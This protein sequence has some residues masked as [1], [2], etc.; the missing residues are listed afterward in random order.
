MKLSFLLLFVCTIGSLSAQITQPRPWS[1]V[2]VYK[3]GQRLNLF[4]QVSFNNPVFAE[5]DLNNN[6]IKD[7]VVLEKAENRLYAFRNNGTPNTIDYVLDMS[8][9]EFFPKE[10]GEFIH[11]ADVNCDSVPDLF[12]YTP[13]GGAGIGIYHGKWVNNR[14]HFDLYINRLFDQN[15]FQLYADQVKL[16]AFVDVNGDG[17]LDILVFDLFDVTLMYYENQRVEIGRCDTLVYK[18]KTNCWGY[19]CEC[20]AVDNTLILN[21]WDAQ[22]CRYNPF[23]PSDPGM[24]AGPD[25][26]IPGTRHVGSTLTPLDIYRDGKVDLLIGDAGYDNLIY[27]LNTGT[28]GAQPVDSITSLDTFF[29]GYGHSVALPVFPAGYHI[30][31]NNDGLKDLIVASFGVNSCYLGGTLDT[32]LVSDNVW[33]YLNVGTSRDSFEL[34]TMNFLMD[35]VA[36][37]GQYTHPVFYDAD[38]DGL[39][40]I[41]I[42]R[43]YDYD[44]TLLVKT[45][46][47]LFRN[48]GT[49][50]APEFTWITDDWAGLSAYTWFGSRPTFGDLDG[51]GDDDLILSDASSGFLYFLR[52][53]AAPGNPPVFIADNTLHPTFSAGAFPSPFLVDVDGDGLLDIIVGEV[54]GRVQYVRNEGTVT[55]PDFKM[56]DT[57][58]GE[59]DGRN[60]EFF[61]YTTPFMGDVDGDGHP[62]LLVGTHS[63][64]IFLYDTLELA[65]PVFPFK[66]ADNNYMRLNW[67]RRIS[68]FG[69]DVNKDGKM[70]F[71]IGNLR[72]GWALYTLGSPVGI[73]TQAR[74]PKLI[75]APNPASGMVYLKLPEPATRAIP[76][77]FD[78][79]GREMEVSFR[80]LDAYS[81]QADVR[82]LPSGVYLLEVQDGNHTY[83]GKLV[84]Q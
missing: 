6:G 7:L 61:G 75:I 13:F 28:S 18:L 15:N 27:L 20:S 70:D 42:G 32:S 12:C 8:L 63:G 24:E 68:P 2:P 74:N 39:L 81:W 37:E 77:C 71:V 49:A 62:E 31:V 36:N 41:L 16:P 67:G 84:K 19:V 3:N 65:L 45:G 66:L 11:M 29:P 58:W 69:A 23:R 60:G 54:Q 25:T 21:Y 53:T 10:V 51:D 1:E 40:D 5:A 52:N 76:R 17:D 14:L 30:D 79:T 83:T 46:F 82:S 34:V 22:Y 26:T 50:S 4:S 59:V 43:C 33:L 55:N 73:E 72:G 48:T 38:Q 47:T 78:I 57:F 64:A 44:S 35:S 9:V 80:P 56:A